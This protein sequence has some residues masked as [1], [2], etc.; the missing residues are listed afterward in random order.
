MNLDAPPEWLEPAL[1]SPFEAVK[2]LLSCAV[3]LEL[4]R[5]RRV[6]GGSPF[7]KVTEQTYRRSEYPSELVEIIEQHRQEL[8]RII[9][10]LDA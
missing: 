6:E 3:F 7:M 10:R 1:E 4:C 9:R 8:L 2:K 5:R